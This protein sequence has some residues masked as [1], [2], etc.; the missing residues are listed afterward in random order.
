[1]DRVGMGDK[2]YLG[3]SLDMKQ[4]VD[5]EVRVRGFNSDVSIVLQST[6]VDER[7]HVKN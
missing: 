5:D 7:L 2:L 1:M 3:C 4:M 6:E